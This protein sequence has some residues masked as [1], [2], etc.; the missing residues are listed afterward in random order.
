MAIAFALGESS[1]KKAGETN[2][3][4]IANWVKQPVSPGSA[5]YLKITDNTNFQ[6]GYTVGPDYTETLFGKYSSTGS[7]VV[8][9]TTG[10][11]QAYCMYVSGIY[12]YTINA[13][14]LNLAVA[15]DPCTDSSGILR[16]Q[17]LDGSWTQ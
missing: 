4:L 15:H 12:N 17:V 6:M 2:A 10:G 8:F 14:Q 1:C 11:Q 9:T 13:N 16:S 7:Q 3:A 5:L